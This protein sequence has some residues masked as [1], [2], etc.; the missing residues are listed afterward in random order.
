MSDRNILFWIFSRKHETTVKT[1]V[2]A[3]VGNERNCRIWKKRANKTSQETIAM[4]KFAKKKFN[5]TVSIKW[6]VFKVF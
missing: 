6:K 5:Q 2:G 4:S 3:K 1:K